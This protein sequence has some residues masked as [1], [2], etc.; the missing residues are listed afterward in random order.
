MKSHQ[1]VIGC[2]AVLFTSICCSAS[3]HAVS[4]NWFHISCYVT[5]YQLFLILRYHFLH[6]HRMTYFVTVIQLFILI[7]P[8]TYVISIHITTAWYNFSYKKQDF[9]SLLP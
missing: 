1:H 8:L 7:Y 3:P 6:S 2:T 5:F 9:Y 4:P